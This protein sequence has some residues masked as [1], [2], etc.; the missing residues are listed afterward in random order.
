MPT[1]QEVQVE[2]WWATFYDPTLDWLISRAM[3]ANLDLEAADERIRASRESLNIARAGQFPAGNLGGSYTRSGAVN[4]TPHNQWQAGLDAAWEVDVFGGIRR[5]VESSNA[6]LEASVEDR[7]DVLVTLLGETAI[8]YLQVRGL[9][10]EIIIAREN[11]DAQK[12]NVDLTGEKIRLGTGT[13]L[14]IS[15][16]QAQVFSTTATI[17]SF[18]EQEQQ[19]V[20][21]LSVLLALPP[22]ALDDELRE[23]GAIP[24]P[25]SVL[26]IGIPSDL[27]RRRP[28]IRRAERQLAAATAQIGVAT[29][30]LF[31]S[32]SLTGSLNVQAAHFG[33]LGNVNNSLWSLGPSV[34]WPILDPAI[35]PNIR[36]QTALQ[37]QSLTAYKQT[38]LNALVE[39]QTA[40]VAYVKLQERWEALTQAV[41]FDKRALELARHRYQQGLTDF[42]NVLVAEQTLL[43]AQ[44]ALVQ[45]DRTIDTNVVTLYKALGGGWETAQGPTTQP[46]Q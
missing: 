9:Q 19:A 31:P 44:D 23:P 24:T 17:A 41:V 3:Q 29:A 18:E 10:Q 30:Q 2:R 5:S 37:E 28:D 25:P 33:G 34:T 40:L 45:T 6:S 16:A 21:A 27:L 32:F 22:T 39:V 8:N 36:L 12:R 46:E 11:L 26:N 20:Y 1:Q 35:W 4:G 13:A 7:R 43:G 38:V 15:Q 42:L 14:D